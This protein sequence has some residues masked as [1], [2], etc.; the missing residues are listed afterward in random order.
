MY[1]LIWNSAGDSLDGRIMPVGTEYLRSWRLVEGKLHNLTLRSKG[2]EEMSNSSGVLR[3]WCKV[4]ILTG[5]GFRENEAMR[6][7]GQI[8]EKDISL[9]RSPTTFPVLTVTCLIKLTAVCGRT[10]CAWVAF[11]DLFQCLLWWIFLFVFKWFVYLLIYMWACAQWPVCGSLR[12]TCNCFM[13]PCG[14]QGMYSGK[15]AKWQV[16]TFLSHLS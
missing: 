10:N 12:T 16:C 5:R 1:R 14:S 15:Q 11:R 9:L 2:C 13:P 8:G 3:G 6:Q 7:Q 4:H